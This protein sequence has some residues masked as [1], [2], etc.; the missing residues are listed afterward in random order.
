M[1]RGACRGSYG[2]R[3]SFSKDE[4]LDEGADQDNDRELAEEE[5]L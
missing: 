2:R 5:A 3:R 4:E 1:L